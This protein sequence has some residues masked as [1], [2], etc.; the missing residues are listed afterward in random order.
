MSDRLT[1]VGE[2]GQARMVDVGDK[3]VTRRIARAEAVVS[4]S[5]ETA[6]LLFSG[7]L[8]KGDAI[9][10]ARVAGIQGAKATSRLIPLCHPLA[11]SVVDI[12][13]ERVD[14]GALITVTAKVSASTGVEMEAMTGASVAA[15]TLYDMIKGV[16]RGAVIS[17]VRLVSKAGGKSGE[18]SR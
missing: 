15:L 17:R 7:G 4:M 1:H 14:E 12:D 9:A 2:D 6:D 5:E 16:E 13:I 10:V 3:E 11:L 8:P 18:W